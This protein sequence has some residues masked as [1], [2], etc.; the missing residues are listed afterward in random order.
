[1]TDID[2]A[3]A[4]AKIRKQ[5]GDG[6]ADNLKNMMTAFK[7]MASAEAD[8]GGIG[9]KFGNRLV[10]ALID[11]Q[12]DIAGGDTNASFGQYDTDLRTILNGAPLTVKNL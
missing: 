1:M 2:F 10:Q 6:A 4:N 11:L 7:T 12:M 5:V 3:G 9:A 8:A